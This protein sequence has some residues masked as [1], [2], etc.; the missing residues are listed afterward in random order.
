VV[1]GAG[2]QAGGWQVVER[3]QRGD[4]KLLPGPNGWLSQTWDRTALK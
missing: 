2:I 1:R 3:V 4:G